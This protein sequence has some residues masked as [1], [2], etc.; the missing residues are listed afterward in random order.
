MAVTFMCERRSPEHV[1]HA[2]PPDDL[3][4]RWRP[5]GDLYATGRRFTALTHLMADLRLLGVGSRLELAGDGEA[6]LRVPRTL[7]KPLAVL[8]VSYRNEWCFAWSRDR[9]ARVEDS[10]AVA[11]EIRGT[12]S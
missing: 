8:C 9:I 4:L 6:L 11:A 1:R 12:R 3:R 10:M 2:C 5:G 7:D